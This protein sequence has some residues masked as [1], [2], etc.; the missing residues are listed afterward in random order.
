MREKN[1]IDISRIVLFCFVI[2]L[3]ATPAMAATTQLHIVKYAKDGITI[4]NETTKT[5]QWME[6][7]LP[8]LG[9]GATH[10][11]S[12]G[13]TF[14]ETDPW[15]DAEWQNIVPDRDWGAVKG[16]DVKDLCD[17]VGGMSAECG[18]GVSP[19]VAAGLCT[20]RRM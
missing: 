4:L 9:D 18:T 5:Y 17:L 8:V 2:I 3:L 6:A 11:Y 20:G 14:N 19:V 16:T 15:D 12:Q 1:M 10:Y 7:N 13:P